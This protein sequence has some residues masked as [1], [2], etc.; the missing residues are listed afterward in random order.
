MSRKLRG[1]GESSIRIQDSVVSILTLSEEDGQLDEHES[2][3]DRSNVSTDSTP[4]VTKEEMV[5]SWTSSMI[6]FGLIR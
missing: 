3:W 5:H 2:F 4:Q 1:C 6:G